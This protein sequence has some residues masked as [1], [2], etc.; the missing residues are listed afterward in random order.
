MRIVSWNIHKGVMGAGPL[1]SLKIHGLS[2]AVQAMQA[3]V[4]CLQEVRHFNLREQRY[5]SDWPQHCQSEV[6]APD[7]YRAVYRTNAVTRH[8]EHG[9]ALVTRYPVQGVFH[10]DMSDHRLEQRGLLHVVLQVPCSGGG[11]PVHVL[12]VHLGLIRGSRLRQ[13]AQLQRYVQQHIPA[14]EQLLIAGD[15]NTSETARK[16]A[17]DAMGMQVQTRLTP[18]FPARLPLL[19][20]DHI[21]WR[22][23]RLR[24]VQVQQRRPWTALSDHLP[25]LL[26]L[27]WEGL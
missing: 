23:G 20:F 10:Q 19:Q 26:D 11:Q 21:F 6:L 2:D 9:N 27:A 17:T 3:D 8:G 15:F 14:D 13:M 4:V 5:F 12:V 1:R 16:W 7:S 18:T 22:Y 25:L 24:M